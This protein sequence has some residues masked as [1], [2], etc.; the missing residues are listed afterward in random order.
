MPE[1]PISYKQYKVHFVKNFSHGD[2]GTKIRNCLIKEYSFSRVIASPLSSENPPAGPISNHPTRPCSPKPERTYSLHV[3][4]ALYLRRHFT[5]FESK[6]TVKSGCQAACRNEWLRGVYVG[7][8]AGSRQ[9]RSFSHPPK[10]WTLILPD[11]F[12]ISCISTGR[13]N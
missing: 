3:S 7:V 13:Y 12:S 10:I 6:K 5:R 11:P 8:F 1:P 9:R 2:P 4:P